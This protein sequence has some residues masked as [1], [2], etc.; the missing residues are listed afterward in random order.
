MKNL[1]F[2]LVLCSSTSIALANPAAPVEAH[3]TLGVDAA[4]VLPAGDYGEV[5]T[6]GAGALGRLEIPAGPGFVTARAGVL[7]HAME[8]G[9]LTLVPVYGGYRQPVGT[10]GLYVA[11][12]LGLTIGFGSVRTPLGTMSASDSELGLTLGAG[13]R[14]G[15][16]DLRAALFLPDADDLVGILGTVGFDFATL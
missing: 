10:G 12:E 7:L 13:L 16:L 15:A 2:S 5:A 4:L 11:G 8:V 9:S 6:A 3:K 1:A 14:R